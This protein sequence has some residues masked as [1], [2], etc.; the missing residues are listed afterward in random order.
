[1]GRPYARREGGHQDLLEPAAG[2]R[3]ARPFPP[4]RKGGDGSGMCVRLCVDT[5]YVTL[6]YT[7]LLPSRL[8]GTG[9]LP[10]LE[11]EEGNSQPGRPKACNTCEPRWQQE[12]VYER[13]IGG[14]HTNRL[15]RAGLRRLP[16]PLLRRGDHHADGEP[17]PQVVPPPRGAAAGRTALRLTHVAVEP[18]TYAA[19]RTGGASGQRSSRSWTATGRASRVRTTSCARRARTPSA[20]RL[21]SRRRSGATC[22]GPTTGRTSP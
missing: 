21:S 20:P 7:I 3:R 8:T 22:R 14:I 1:M 19:R 17:P 12:R 16:C 4:A 11:G 5:T 18:L 9:S 6:A 10:R 15:P 13:E 2:G